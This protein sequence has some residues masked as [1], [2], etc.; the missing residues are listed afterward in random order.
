MSCVAILRESKHY[1]Q[2]VSWDPLN[3]FLVTMSND[4]TCRIYNVSRKKLLYANRK[5]EFL[6]DG[7]NISKKLYRDENLPSFFRRCSFSPDGQLLITPSGI[8]LYDSNN[9]ESATF[10]YLRSC[11][12][13]F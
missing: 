12:T 10:V 11:L 5:V 1:L 4:T 7:N 2:G 6:Q 13:K 3:E 8:S 9:Q